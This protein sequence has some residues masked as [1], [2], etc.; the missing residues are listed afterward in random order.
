MGQYDYPRERAININVLPSN[1]YWRA[2]RLHP[3]NLLMVAKASKL[4]GGRYGLRERLL[5]SFVAISGFSVIAAVVGI[6]VFYAIGEALH[7]VTDK[8][9]PPA[10]AT[11]ELAQRTEHIVAAGPALLAAAN[12]SQ[13][14]STSA[15]VEEEVKQA[16]LLLNELPDKGV[17][18]D[19]LIEIQDVFNQVAANLGGLKSAAQRR[20]AAANHK[21]T[22]VSDIYHAYGRFRAVWTPKFEEL[23][24]HI[25]A[26]QRSL[27]AAESTPEARLAALNRLNSALQDLTPLEQIQQ[28]AANAFESLMRVASADTQ[29]AVDSFQQQVDRAVRRIDDLVSG[30]DPDVSLALIVPLS[31]LRASA[32]GSSNIKSARQVELDAAY[33]GQRLIVENSA[34]SAQLSKAVQ[35]LGSAA[36]QGIAEATEET[37]SVQRR[38]RIGL[39]AVVA[40][41]LISS[42]LI[43]WLYVGRNIV[44]RL[45][46][47]S[48]AMLSITSGRRDIS[49]PVLGSDEVAAMGRA[50]EVFRQ[51][52]VE[53]DQLLAER[54]D[55]ATR[56]EKIVKERTAELQRRG[57]VLR[58][59]FDNMQHGVLMFDRELKLAAW[60]RQVMRLLDLP[61]TY[62]AG[63]PRF[64]DFIRFLADRGEY[65]LTNVETEVQRLVAAAAQHH[66]FERT[67]PNGAV[68][69][70]RHNPL[71]EGGFVIIYTDITA[72]KQRERELEAA[73]DVAAEASRTME[74][75]YRELKATQANLVHAEKMASLGQLTAGIAHEI[76]N[77]LNF[78]NNFAGVSTELLDELREALGPTMGG[79]SAETCAEV[80]TLI[81]TLNNN[82]SK[83]AEHGRRA[84]G[85]VK[86]MLLHSRGGSGERQ[87][88]DINPLIEEA[89]NLAYHG[90]RAQDKEFNITI[91]RDLDSSLGP[92]ELV[93]QDITRVFLNL[94]GNSFYATKK[95]QQDGKVGA[96]YRP[97]LRVT[98]RDLGDK[99]EARVRD[100]GVGVPAD[101]QAKMFTPFFTTKPTGEGT[102]L[103]LSISYDIV[104]QQ[105]GGTITVESRVNEF[106][107]F[108]I[109][110]PRKP[111]RAE[112]L[113]RAVGVRA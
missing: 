32:M 67:R 66:A 63:E 91:E 89:L 92:I 82:L 77:P 31:Q 19:K 18:T 3:A 38:G 12:N 42:T 46:Q 74:E 64:T 17:P 73:R 49:V 57:A 43:G 106:T 83:I 53:L 97:V 81:T 13:F 20:I 101:V 95:R 11:L 102:G 110:L 41:S 47:L 69:E 27:D 34:L 35:A 79:L 50:V 80:E 5:L 8:S 99:V 107:E 60:N 61:E 93:P 39:L 22:L 29:A 4:I 6:Y 62:L 25:A 10:I 112:K 111:A 44:A 76:K 85:I 70:I 87:N 24:G 48:S 109:R 84:D 86:S 2:Q 7:R 15:A 71:P 108:V 104:T 45:T 72:A 94:F 14:S 54:A 33:D 52:A 36:K 105:H 58:V 78:V 55:A 65:G 1:C 96:V 113:R 26:L 56:L 30:L 21:A 59:T 103:G 75:A 28:Q 100:N 88:V 37:Q 9:V 40:L 16:A 68:L 51:N 98:T 90:A 23:K